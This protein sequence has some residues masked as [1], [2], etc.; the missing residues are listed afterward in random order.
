MTV[1]NAAKAVA[2]FKRTV[3]TPNRPYD[4]F[5]K[6]ETDA[7]DKQQQR[8]MKLFAEI[9]CTSCHSGP[10]FS[11]PAA[12]TGSGFFMKFP[13]FEGK[14]SVAKYYLTA[15]LG[16]FEVTG[17][18]ADQHLFKVPTLRNI[19][20]TA[21]CFHNGSVP[22]LREAVRVMAQVQLDNDLKDQQV[23]DIVAFLEGLTGEFP[24]QVLPRLPATE[25]WSVTVGKKSAAGTE[26]RAPQLLVIGAVGQLIPSINDRAEQFGRAF[27]IVFGRVSLFL[28]PFHSRGNGCA[29]Q[30]CL[31]E[32]QPGKGRGVEAAERVKRIALDLVAVGRGIDEIQ[33]KRRVMA[34]QN[35]AC[36]GV[37]P[38]R[39]AHRLE[40]HPQRF[41]FRFR[42]TERVVRV[43][44]GKFQGFFVQMRAGERFH[45]TG[46]AFRRM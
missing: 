42:K 32:C 19:A 28:I 25:G 14:E 39:A 30:D 1:E 13:Q 2:A 4:R 7:L 33:V 15:D 24:E 36:A 11:G 31:T 18:E 3:I 12:A 9:G 40:N 23:A 20:L 16:R 45:M 35:S 5:V 34:N 8:G 6:G 38:Y 44:P 27:R 10:A 17:K 46:V 29:G 21:P 43:D 22:T 41:L 26:P 37:F